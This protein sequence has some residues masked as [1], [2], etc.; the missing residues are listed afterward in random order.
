MGCPAHRIPAA[1]HPL[2]F[3]NRRLG[4]RARRPGVESL[5]GSSYK[6]AVPLS[7]ECPNIAVRSPSLA[8]SCRRRSAASRRKLSGKPWRD[9][10]ERPILSRRTSWN[11]LSAGGQRRPRVTV[12][13]IFVW[14]EESGRRRVGGLDTDGAAGRLFQRPAKPLGAFFPTSTW[15]PPLGRRRLLLGRQAPGRTEVA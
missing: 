11:G 2:F 4:R 9:R 3:G 12:R 14:V 5:A 1:G 10:P 8:V 6:A 15:W 13:G 7:G